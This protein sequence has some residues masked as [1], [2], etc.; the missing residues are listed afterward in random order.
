VIRDLPLDG[1][2]AEAERVAALPDDAIFSVNES[3]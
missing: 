2:A 1:F 3:R